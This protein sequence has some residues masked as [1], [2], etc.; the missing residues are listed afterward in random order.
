MCRATVPLCHC[1]TQPD[2]DHYHLSLLTPQAI[3]PFP[4]AF[5][6]TVKRYMQQSL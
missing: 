6:H 1:A 5:P 2:H 3:T 4:V